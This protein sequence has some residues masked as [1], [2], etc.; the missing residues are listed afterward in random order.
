MAEVDLA[1]SNPVPPEAQLLQ[2]LRTLTGL[3]LFTE[4]A[5]HG[6]S[7]QPMGAALK[8]GTPSRAAALMIAGEFMGSA[9]D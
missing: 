5:A 3:G 6:F 2:V 7:L 1:K 8:S 4:D 9:I